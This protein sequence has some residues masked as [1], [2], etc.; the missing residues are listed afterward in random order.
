MIQPITVGKPEFRQKKQ[1]LLSDGVLC[2]EKLVENGKLNQTHIESLP[3]CN[4][5]KQESIMNPTT[6]QHSLF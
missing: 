4:S 5:V 6:H 3:S 1:L 2:Q